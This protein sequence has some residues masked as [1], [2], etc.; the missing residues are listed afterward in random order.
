M[1]YQYKILNCFSSQLKPLLKKFPHIRSDLASALKEFKKESAV[2]LGYGT[3]K[4]RIRS[5][6]LRKGK[7]GSFRCIVYIMELEHLL[8]PISIF[9]KSE[10]DNMTRDEI[11]NAL[12]NAITEM[13]RL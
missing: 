9:F 8:V 13:G 6:D 7:S 12:K 10:Q 5:S 2:S 1:T 3:Y 11:Q 4:L